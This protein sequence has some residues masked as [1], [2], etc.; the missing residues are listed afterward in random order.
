MGKK[1]LNSLADLKSLNFKEKKEDNATPKEKAV[2]KAM[3][4][5]G[6][7]SA[8][9]KVKEP[10]PVQNAPLSDEETFLSAM[11]GVEKLDDD[12]IEPLAHNKSK[13]PPNLPSDDE[14]KKALAGLLSGKIEF[15]IEYCDDY[16]FGF[17]RGIDSKIFQKLKAGAFSYENYVDL[18]GLNSEQA[19]DSLHFFIRESYLH[20]NRCVLVVTG[21]G[22]NSPGGQSVLKREVHDWL[23][24]D[25]FKRVVL[26]FCTAQPKD[27][28]AGALYVLLRKQKKN[29]GKIQWD[30]GRNWG[31]DDF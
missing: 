25:P 9:K 19:Y 18:H 6:L 28:G 20:G 26:A 3:K 21:K 10:E 7:K 17:V 15:E 5:A 13:P 4:K 8:P 14:D 16:M 31:K 30:K 1:K 12:K 23:T 22:R 24:R 11:A 29:G 27:G 2:K